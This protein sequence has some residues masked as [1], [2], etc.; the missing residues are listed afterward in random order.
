MAKALA[1]IRD[2]RLYR[3][4]HP[5]FE[6]Y[7]QQ[8]WA[9]TARRARQL[10]D[11]AEI[12][13]NLEG[14]V[15]DETSDTMGTTVLIGT[16][17]KHVTS[18]VLPTSERQVRPLSRLGHWQQREVWQKAVEASQGTPSEQQV[19]KIRDEMF[20][21][22]KK[23]EESSELSSGVTPVPAQ[24]S[25]A[26][27]GSK[28]TREDCIT[29]LFRLVEVLADCDDESFDMDFLEAQPLDLQKFRAVRSK[30]STLVSGVDAFSKTGRRA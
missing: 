13:R 11:A 14:S 3:E 5:T 16:P 17:N 23:K 28:A 7:C 20:P 18:G 21:Q 29:A 19:K 30:L 22:S 25:A 12:V 1:Q 15:E 10:T 9:V 2:Q 26:E 6:A 27:V 4:T 24:D 8:R